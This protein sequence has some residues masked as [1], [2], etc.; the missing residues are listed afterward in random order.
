MGP[1]FDTDALALLRRRVMLSGEVAQSRSC[2][3]DRRREQ[4]RRSGNAA[5]EPLT[6]ERAEIGEHLP[7]VPFH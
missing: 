7:G 1:S 3:I 6:K 4:S 5:D 2:E